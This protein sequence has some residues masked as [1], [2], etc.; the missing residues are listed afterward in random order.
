MASPGFYNWNKGRAYPFLKDTVDGDDGFIPAFPPPPLGY[1]S[2]TL[3]ELPNATIVDCGF[4]TAGGIEFDP[5]VHQV[6]LTDVLRDSGTITFR[7]GS[8]CPDLAGLSLDFT[9]SV[10]DRNYLT[11]FASIAS[12]PQSLSSS[13][14]DN[15][16][17]D[18]PAWCGFL[19]TADLSGLEDI[20][21]D[22]M[23]MAGGD[24][25]AVVEPALVAVDFS[26][27]V[28]SVNLANQD[29]TRSLPPVDCDPIEWPYTTGRIFVSARCLEGDLDFVPGAN[30]DIRVSQTG[31]S[32]TFRATAGR[33]VVGV[34]CGEVPL[35][36]IEAAP[37]GSDNLDGSDGCG[38]V[39]R[40]LNGLPGPVVQFIPDRGL[41][42]EDDQAGH[43]VI[44]SLD[45]GDF[46][47][48]D[49]GSQSDSTSTSGG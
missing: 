32:V 15:A 37:E 27:R 41:R 8:T 12:P 21:P 39:L 38:A 17:C 47:V 18:V 19:V 23:A 49:S 31:N 9:R 1:I 25:K 14:D 22:G 7:F 16:A 13:V 40:T 44:I 33:G 5:A 34:L 2:T 24:N 11:S 10:G 26:R 20:L 35:F 6:R 4:R 29:R 42:I 46:L 36:A 3:L 28:E 30:T 43:R 45:L 48:S